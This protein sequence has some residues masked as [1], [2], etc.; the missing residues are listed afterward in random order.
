MDM[1]LYSVEHKLS[2]APILFG[3]ATSFSF[4]LGDKC[5]ILEH[6]GIGNLLR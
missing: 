3:K 5:L 1:M 6:I 2:I 4:P